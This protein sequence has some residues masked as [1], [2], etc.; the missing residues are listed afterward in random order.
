M[1]I[2]IVKAADLEAALTGPGA[3][4]ADF[5]LTTAAGAAA[6]PQLSP[7]Q[8]GTVHALLQEL[9]ASDNGDAVLTTPRHRLAAA[10]QSF[11]AEK[12]SSE[13]KYE[14]V[15]GRPVAKYSPSDLIG[16]A[17]SFF[18]W[19]RSLFPHEWRRP[20]DQPI[21]LPVACRIGMLA[22][23]GTGMYGAPECIKRMRQS[24]AAGR[25]FDI[26]IHLGDVYYSGTPAE[27]RKLFLD[28]W[29]VELPRWNFCLNGNHDMYSGGYGYFDEILPAFGQASSCVW[30]QNDN[31]TIVG[32]DSG[33]HE[34]DI[35]P[36]QVE[37]LKRVIADSQT[38]NRRVIVLTHHQPFSIL[39]S[40][41]PKLLAD[42]NDLLSGH[43]IVE[44]LRGFL[45]AKA[46]AAW[47]FGHEHRLILYERHAKW[48]LFARCIGHGG[49]PYERAALEGTS[50]E[51]TAMYAVR[52]AH[53]IPG[54]LVLDGP[55]PFV[56]G[57]QNKY[58][59][60][61]YAVYELNGPAIR[62]EYVLADGQPVYSGM[63]PL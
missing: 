60:N 25:P 34:N 39:S 8:V 31:F 47:I 35:S 5:A 27:S 55:N 26:L 38:K 62:E 53:G 9:K 17:L 20:P 2:T 41:G 3:L 23:W 7:L 13:G 42:I 19:W 16:W 4:Q 57:Y 28:Q 1:A 46:I 32:L 43:H 18:E 58:G 21:H 48:N 40:E 49:M 52:G 11:V 63:M 51:A 29:P 30:L 14:L 10:F 59:P 54:A 24:A 33:Y 61:G 50:P 44:K 56:A 12:A 45:E 36:D 22:D 37:W 15:M 6:A